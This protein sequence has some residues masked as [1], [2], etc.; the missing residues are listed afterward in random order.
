M[1][2]PLRYSGLT[3]YQS[4]YHKMPSGE[5]Y[6]TLSVVRNNGFLIPILLF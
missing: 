6:T 5:E 2:D 1:N 4:N 3:F